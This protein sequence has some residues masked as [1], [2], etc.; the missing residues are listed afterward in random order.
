MTEKEKIAKLSQLLSF[1]ETEVMPRLDR[2]KTWLE[3]ITP[4]ELFCLC[5][6][7]TNLLNSLYKIDKKLITELNRQS[8]K[9]LSELNY[10][11]L[12]GWEPG[13]DDFNDGNTTPVLFWGKVLDN[14]VYFRQDLDTHKWL[15]KKYCQNFCKV[16][17]KQT[18]IDDADRWEVEDIWAK[19]KQ[20]KC[21]HFI[22]YSNAVVH[23]IR[24]T[25]C[26]AL[27]SYSVEKYPEIRCGVIQ[28]KLAEFRRMFIWGTTV[29]GPYIL[30]YDGQWEGDFGRDKGQISG[31]LSLKFIGARDGVKCKFYPDGGYDCIEWGRLV[32]DLDS[33]AGRLYIHEDNLFET[34]EYS[35]GRYFRN[36]KIKGEPYWVVKTHDFSDWLEYYAKP[37]EELAKPLLNVEPYREIINLFFELI[38]NRQAKWN[39]CQVQWPYI[40][41]LDDLIKKF[42]IASKQAL[43][44]GQWSK[45]M[46]KVDIRRILTHLLTEFKQIKNYDAEIFYTK[47]VVSDK[48]DIRILWH[49]LFAPL[50][51]EKD[52]TVWP[53]YTEYALEEYRR[54]YGPIHFSET[55]G[56]KS[57]DLAPYPPELEIQK[58]ENTTEDES[59]KPYT[60]THGTLY[61]K[62]VIEGEQLLQDPIRKAIRLL[63][64]QHYYCQK[65]PD[66]DTFLNWFPHFAAQSDT[67]KSPVS[68]EP[69]EDTVYWYEFLLKLS[70][71]HGSLIEGD[72]PTTWILPNI[73]HIPYKP[74]IQELKTDVLKASILALEYLLEKASKPLS[75]GEQTN[76]AK[77]GAKPKD[78][79]TNTTKQTTMRP[80]T[81]KARLIYDKLYALKPQEA[82]TMPEI[83]DWIYNEHSINLDE[84][85]WKDI[86]KELIP[87]GLKNRPRVG[88]YIEKK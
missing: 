64:L 12:D 20:K 77:M 40:K 72:K 23:N 62:N 24:D 5:Y 43:S 6:D 29:I 85:T 48:D 38:R 3:P 56:G 28:H 7:C 27:I 59:E 41:E 66:S 68:Y 88:Y 44:E 60:V 32:A 26:E 65:M 25:L 69:H 4:G 14:V 58:E 22:V 74:I 70:L 75:I 86:R 52:I 76:G 78:I 82:M 84:G 55:P 45:P 33:A 83:Q 42:E 35:S 11:L 79:E 61:G 34:W 71:E 63:L 53:N 10:G 8:T 80:L 50:K 39:P 19:E 31:Q 2:D 73:S 30:N 57:V 36:P 37:I 87:Y 21:E 16:I 49:Y 46:S 18:F 51:R 13:G 54:V 81:R 67:F 47:A 17:A 9:S 1:A 15:P